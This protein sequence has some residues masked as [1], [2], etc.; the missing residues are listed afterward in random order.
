MARNL[1]T[2]PIYI[3][4]MTHIVDRFILCMYFLLGELSFVHFASLCICVVYMNVNVHYYIFF[5]FDVYVYVPL[6]F[7]SIRVLFV[8]F[9]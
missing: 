2:L 7:L 1:A 3:I 6:F 8:F 9:V 4:Y 5:Q